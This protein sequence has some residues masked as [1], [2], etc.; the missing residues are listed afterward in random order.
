MALEEAERSCKLEFCLK[1]GSKFFGQSKSE[2]RNNLKKGYGKSVM[3]NGDVILG[4][5]DDNVLQ[6]EGILIKDNGDIYEGS[7]K[8]GLFHGAGSLIFDQV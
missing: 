7:F 2:V 3:T 5:F 4:N 1:D 6:G 8:D